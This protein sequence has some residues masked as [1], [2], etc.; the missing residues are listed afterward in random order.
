MKK[1]IRNLINDNNDNDIAI[2]SDDNK[3]IN[4]LELKEHV[5]NISGQLS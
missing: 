2:T 4:F 3:P 1:T 5:Y